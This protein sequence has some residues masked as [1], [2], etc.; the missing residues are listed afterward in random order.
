MKATAKKIGRPSYININGHKIRTP[1]QI[2]KFNPSDKERH[3]YGDIRLQ[4]TPINISKESID[5]IPY[6]NILVVLKKQKSQ[7][8]YVAF[9]V[10]YSDIIDSRKQRLAHLLNEEKNALN[11]TDEDVILFD[12][13][14]VIS[15][16][17]CNKDKELTRKELFE[18]F[19]TSSRPSIIAQDIKRIIHLK[20]EQSWNNG[21]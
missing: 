2:V 18:N 5:K 21:K 15:D 6:T 4:D 17:L 19:L 16:E 13:H 14:Q 20:F 3:I 1:R 10:V 9:P 12:A 7:G 8:S 11:S